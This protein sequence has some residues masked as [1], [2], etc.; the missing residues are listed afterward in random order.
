[1]IYDAGI[2]ELNGGTHFRTENFGRGIKIGVAMLTRIF[3]A[4]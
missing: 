1:M 3:R 2:E 4:V